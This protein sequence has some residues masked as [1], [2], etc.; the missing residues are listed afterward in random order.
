MSSTHVHKIG[1]ANHFI[2][3][4]GMKGTLTLSNNALTFETHPMNFRQYTLEMPLSDIGSVEI[5]N[6]LRF[7]P[8]GIVIT[9]REGTKHR[10]A[11]WG[12]KKWVRAIKKSAN[13]GENNS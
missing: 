13:I 10:F 9:L 5:R 4:I 1:R 11:V 3:E 8:Y 6:N 7:F 2:D 12:R